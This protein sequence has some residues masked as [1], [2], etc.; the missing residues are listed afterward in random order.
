LA[1][2]Q[3]EAA[4]RAQQAAR[5]KIRLEGQ[6]RKLL[7]GHY[8]GAIPPDLLASEMQRLTRALADASAEIAAANASLGSAAHTL[9]AAL[10]AAAHVS[11]QYAA[12]PPA[13]RR[14]INQGF[15]RT[16]YIGED[17]TVDRV[18][19]TEPFAR[20]L[21]QPSVTEASSTQDSLPTPYLARGNDR[22]L[23][24]PTP[25]EEEACPSVLPAA[26]MATP[27]RKP[28]GR[29]VNVTYLVELRGRLSN[30]EAAEVVA[31]AERA[32]A[33]D[34]PARTIISSPSPPRATRPWRLVDRL[35]EK[36]IRRLVQDRRSGLSKSV[37]ADR[38]SI[39]LSSVKR[40]TK[41]TDSG[42]PRYF[43]LSQ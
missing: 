14:Q 3:R 23:N 35:G 25:Y 10:R 31:L 40:F 43:G 5:R 4:R 6:R 12:A 17:G 41:E 20:L 21:P 8:A 29:G 16:I 2:Q 26:T 7:E 28:S 11:S 42:S 34:T 33:G 24:R 32:V 37:L 18:D 9:N 19:F 30:P 13:I 38:Y 36:I 1:A 39:S 22:I 15:F 27:G